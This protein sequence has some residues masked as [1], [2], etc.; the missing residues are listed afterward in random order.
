MTNLERT[1]LI[2]RY[3]AH[4]M[5]DEE[6]MGF[7]RLL[8]E[9]DL[10][11][12]N[13]ANLR[14]EMELQKDIE[15]AIRERGLREMLQKEET[16]I[17]KNKRTKRITLWSFCSGSIVTALAAIMLLLFVVEPMSRQMQYLS[18][19]YVSQVD[20]SNSRG[21][22]D[23]ST[24][25]DNA[26]SLMQSDKW[27][28][29]AQM[30][31]DILIRTADSPNEEMIEMHNSAEWL[32]AIYLMHDGKIYKAKRLLRKISNSESHYNVAAGEMLKQL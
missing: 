18:T 17:R 13:E 16:H 4:E 21:G 3:L 12:N 11:Y 15:N 24:S 5:S 22:N 6:H 31:D 10:S 26:L 25:I 29:A 32:K 28:E 9:S 30:I 19:Q 20:I 1:K 14:K 27:N 2:D 8:S 7:E 23:Y